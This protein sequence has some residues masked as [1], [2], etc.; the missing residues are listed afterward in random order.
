MVNSKY[1][2]L[3][4]YFYFLFFIFYFGNLE[5]GLEWHHDHIV[6]LVTSD[7]MLIVMVTSYKVI[8]KNVEGSGRMTSCHIQVHPSRK[9]Y[10]H[11]DIISKLYKPA[12]HSNHLS[13]NTSYGGAVILQVFCLPWWRYSYSTWSSMTELLLSVSQHWNLCLG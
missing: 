6:I 3:F 8:E 10:P 2:I 1:F 5:L 7:D 11:D 9:L 12:F 13:C 4:S